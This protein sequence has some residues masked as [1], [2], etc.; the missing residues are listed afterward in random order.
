MTGRR[1]GA[2]TDEDGAIAKKQLLRSA[3]FD[4]HLVRKRVRTG[5]MDAE[6]TK[7]AIHL[8]VLLRT[9][10]IHAGI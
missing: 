8:D 1:A 6:L 4:S 2:R 7:Y 10:A 3:P 5:R 9:E